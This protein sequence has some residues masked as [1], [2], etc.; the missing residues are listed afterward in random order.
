MCKFGC[1]DLYEE[2]HIYIDDGV[3]K[4]NDFKPVIYLQ[5]QCKLCF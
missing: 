3:V 2:G 5:K 1:D 4:K